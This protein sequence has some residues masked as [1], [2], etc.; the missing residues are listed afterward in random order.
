[1]VKNSNSNSVSTVGSGGQITGHWDG[2]WQVVEVEK[3]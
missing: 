1:M 3:A 2:A